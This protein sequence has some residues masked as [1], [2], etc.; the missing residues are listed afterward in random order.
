MRENRERKRNGRWL[1]GS[2][3]VLAVV[4][5]LLAGWWLTNPR[6]QR[7]TLPD[8]TVL[9]L[10]SDI[11]TGRPYRRLPPILQRLFPRPRHQPH[12][13]GLCTSLE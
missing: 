6:L 8:G 3:A 13:P 10:D 12:Y 9:I 11:D 2:A 5:L 4:L 7:A 1:A